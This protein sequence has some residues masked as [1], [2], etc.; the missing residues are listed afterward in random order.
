MSRLWGD[1]T[2][3]TYLRRE[4]SHTALTPHRTCR[5]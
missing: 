3:R 1:A 5:R 2:H 4:V